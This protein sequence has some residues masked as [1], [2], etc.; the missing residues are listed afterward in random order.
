MFV[1]SYLIAP[2]ESQADNQWLSDWTDFHHCAQLGF[3]VLK[4]LE[5]LI[6]PSTSITC[7]LNGPIWAY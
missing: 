4:D 7:I 5:E 6:L 2:E 1:D 3:Q